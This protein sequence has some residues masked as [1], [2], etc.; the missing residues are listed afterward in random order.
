MTGSIEEFLTENSLRRYP[1]SEDCSLA[2]QSGSISDDV[3]LDFRAWHRT[4][5]GRSAALAAIVGPDGAGDGIFEAVAGAY[6]VYFFLG[7]GDVVWRFEVPALTP[8]FPF[9]ALSVIQDSIYPGSN[10]GV[11][12]ATFGRGLVQL[13]ADSTLV[14]PDAPLEPSLIFD[15][16]R[17][18]VDHIRLVHEGS[19][20]EFVGGDVEVV[21]GYN[22]GVS[23]IAKGIRV[24]PSPGAGTLG[25]FVG[26]INSPESNKCVGVLLSLAGAIPNERTQDLVLEGTNGVEV[27]NFPDESR[28]RI[29]VAPQHFGGTVCS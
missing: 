18:Q 15:Q 1:F 3:V 9:T 16:Y 14:F 13:A 17:L 21:G 4:R 24:S 8:S 6:S 11:A 12:R 29:R 2:H 10:L 7:Q 20:D 26:S 25:R 22:V 23:G 19:D 27:L 5:T 28:I